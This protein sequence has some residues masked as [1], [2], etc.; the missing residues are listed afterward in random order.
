MILIADSGSTKTDWRLLDGE[1]VMELP[2]TK[3]MNPYHVLDDYIKAE[4]ELATALVEKE[5]VKA[6]CFYGAGVSTTVNQERLRKVFTSVFP[7]A[8]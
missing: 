7:K 3:G 2:Q 5:K 8:V 1:K 6:L 4:L